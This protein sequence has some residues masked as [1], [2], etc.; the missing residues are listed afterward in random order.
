MVYAT[1][2]DANSVERLGLWTSTDRL[3]WTRHGVVMQA[4]GDEGEIGMSHVVHD[5]DDATYPFKMWYATKYVDGRSTDI[6]YATSSNGTSW[7]RRGTCYVKQHTDENVAILLDCVCYDDALGLWRM[8][9]TGIESLNPTRVNAVEARCATPGGAYTR[10][11]TVMQPQGV[12]RILQSSPAPGARWVALD[13]LTGV[14]PGGMFV[15]GTTDGVR[16]QRVVVEEVN[17]NQKTAKLGESIAVSGGGLQM[18]SVTLNR[19]SP[20]FFYRDENGVGRGLF[21]S[22]GAFD[23]GL[24]EYIFPVVETE[25][26][27]AL[28]LRLNPPCR[29]YGPGN[30]RS[31]ENVTPLRSG[32][33]AGPI[34]IP[35]PSPIIEAKMAL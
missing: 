13:S 27:F 18:R 10:R 9:M 26:G 16:A 24:C 4:Q 28:D 33:K 19:I 34:A 35:W 7:T 11:G 21:T 30:S 14:E 2:L 23:N 25:S 20:S 22:F 6:R 31:F 8:F 5:P 1:G 15:L 3:S 12:T 32:L 17:A 29:P